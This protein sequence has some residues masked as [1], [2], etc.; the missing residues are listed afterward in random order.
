MEDP[1]EEI[2]ENQN[3]EVDNLCGCAG[4]EKTRS[5]RVL[6]QFHEPWCFY[7]LHCEEQTEIVED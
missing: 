2:L 7:W 3:H 1:T 4:K 6:Q 5:R